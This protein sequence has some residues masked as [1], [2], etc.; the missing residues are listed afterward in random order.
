MKNNVLLT[1]GDPHLSSGDKTEDTT[2]PKLLKEFL[3]AS[4]KEKYQLALLGDVYETCQAVGGVE[5]I[6]DAHGEIHNIIKNGANEGVFKLASGNH[7]KNLLK[8]F[9]FM[10]KG[11]T[12]YVPEMG[13]KLSHGHEIEGLYHP[14]INKP[15]EKPLIRI[16]G[17]IERFIDK[18]IDT[19]FSRWVKGGDA[20]RT[21]KFYK[22]A[23]KRVMR[24]KYP[25]H[26]FAHFHKPDFKRLE[27]ERYGKIKMEDLGVTSEPREIEIS[28][29]NPKERYIINVGGNVNDRCDYVFLRK[30][31]KNRYV[32]DFLDMR[33][34][35]GESF[36]KGRSLI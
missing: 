21:D 10:K 31:G 28:R 36:Y 11:K 18:D 25:V 4:L 29:K 7:D 24:S 19:K 3:K 14:I 27:K 9:G 34:G 2:N 23:N 26:I 30:L 5:G 20:G 17:I 12:L 32:V 16:L 22:Y 35:F 1:I 6:K 13:A 33:D 15:W 8:Y